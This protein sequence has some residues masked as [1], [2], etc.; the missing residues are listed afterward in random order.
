MQE[1]KLFLL[2][3]L[4]Q[5]FLLSLLEDQLSL[6]LVEQVFPVEP[7][8]QL[9]LF[10]LN[11]IQIQKFIAFWIIH[12][13]E[14]CILLFL[15]LRYSTYT[16]Q[17]LSQSIYEISYQVYPIIAEQNYT[18]SLALTILLENKQSST[19]IGP[20]LFVE[21][22]SACKDVLVDR[23]YSYFLDSCLFCCNLIYRYNIS[24]SST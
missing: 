11:Q 24:Y 21:N 10:K 5:L 23:E 8:L 14:A 12:I 9:T 7:S 20:L 22:I 17:Y 16:I 2:Y 1:I 13:I 6:L 15:L 19:S 18:G 3:I 4:F